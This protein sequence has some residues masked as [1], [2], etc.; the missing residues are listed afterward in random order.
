M[1]CEEDTHLKRFSLKVAVLAVTAVS[2]SGAA[3]AGGINQFVA[4]GDSTM[5]SGYFL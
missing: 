1:V 2:A 5:D 4:F 3:S